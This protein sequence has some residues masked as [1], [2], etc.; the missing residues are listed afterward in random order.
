M[1]LGFQLRI[2]TRNPARHLD[3]KHVEYLTQLDF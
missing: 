3:W 1:N 2:Q